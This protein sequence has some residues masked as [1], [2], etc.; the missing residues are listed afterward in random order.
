MLMIDDPLHKIC[1]QGQTTRLH[2]RG[3]GEISASPPK[4]RDNGDE[5]KVE[6]Y[7]DKTANTAPKTRPNGSSLY[8]ICVAL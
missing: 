7:E 6:I 5:G 8:I 4:S 1:D 2:K 3:Y